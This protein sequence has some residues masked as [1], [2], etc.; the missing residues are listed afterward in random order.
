MVGNPSFAGLGKSC[1][2]SD[3]NGAHNGVVYFRI[4]SRS[5]PNDQGTSVLLG[6]LLFDAN[7]HRV[8]TNKVF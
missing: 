5:F 1:P 6:W 3:Q 8:R 7:N 4:G 2:S